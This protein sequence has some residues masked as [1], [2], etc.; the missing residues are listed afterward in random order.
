MLLLERHSCTAWICVVV[1][2][3]RGLANLRCKLIFVYM[4]WL[5]DVFLYASDLERASAYDVWL[6]CKYVDAEDESLFP[7]ILMWNVGRVHS[8]VC[9]CVETAACWQGFVAWEVL[10]GTLSMD[11]CACVVLCGFR[12]HVVVWETLMEFALHRFVFGVSCPISVFEFLGGIFQF[13]T[14]LEYVEALF[15]TA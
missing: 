4:C 7:M 1:Y 8:S 15:V 9:D 3:S 6:C 12:L 2:F 14:W 10:E 11:L 13:E 5:V